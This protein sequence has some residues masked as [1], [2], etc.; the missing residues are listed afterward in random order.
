MMHYTFSNPVTIRLS[1]EVF[2][3]REEGWLQLREVRT[4]A[5]ALQA[6]LHPFHRVKR[7]EGLYLSQ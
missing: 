2:A 6:S 1:A 5:L 7:F 4:P 3:V